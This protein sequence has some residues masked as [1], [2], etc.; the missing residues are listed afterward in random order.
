[1]DR[2]SWK[3]KIYK[4]DET[5]DY[6]ATEADQ[7]EVNDYLDILRESGVTNMFGA[8]SYIEEE[9]GVDG[10]E[11]RKL[12]QNWME[13]FGK[14]NEGD[15]DF[16]NDPDFEG[17]INGVSVEPSQYTQSGMDHTD[18]SRGDIDTESKASERVVAEITKYQ[19]NCGEIFDTIRDISDHEYFMSD[20]MGDRSHNTVNTINTTEIIQE[21]KASETNYF[22]SLDASAEDILNRW[23]ENQNEN[24]TGEELPDH[25]WDE[26]EKT[27]GGSRL[28][29]DDIQNYIDDYFNTDYDGESKATED[30]HKKS[31][32]KL[33]SIA[34]MGFS[35]IG[36]DQKS[37]D[38]EP[39]EIRA[40]MEKV[41]KDNLGENWK[42]VAN[43]FYKEELNKGKKNGGESSYENWIDELDPIEIIMDNFDPDNKDGSV[44]CDH[45]GYELIHDGSIMSTNIQREAKDHMINNHINE[46]E[47][48]A[49]S[50]TSESKADDIRNAIAQDHEQ[51][52]KKQEP[53]QARRF[54]NNY[55]IPLSN[56][57]SDY[58]PYDWGNQNNFSEDGFA[59]SDTL[60][61]N[62]GQ[63]WQEG[64]EADPCWKGYK[65]IGMK[66]KNGK[67][68]PNCVPNANESYLVEWGYDLDYDFAEIDNLED[69]KQKAID[70]GGN[71][72][73]DNTLVYSVIPSKKIDPANDKSSFITA[74]HL[75]NVESKAN[76]YDCES[77][78]GEYSKC[79][80]CGHAMHDYEWED[81]N[82]VCDSCEKGKYDES[83]S[84]EGH[85]HRWVK[86][87][88]TDFCLDCDEMRPTEYE[89]GAK[90]YDHGESKANEDFADDVIE[91]NT[92]CWKCNT[93]IPLGKK[94]CEMHCG[95]P[96]DEFDSFTGKCTGCGKS[97]NVNMMMAMAESKAKEGLI[98]NIEKELLKFGINLDK[99]PNQIKEVKAK[100][101]E[102][103]VNDWWDRVTTD[104]GDLDMQFRGTHFNELPLHQQNHY[105]NLYMEELGNDKYG[106]HMALYDTRPDSYSSSDLWKDDPSLGNKD[107]YYTGWKINEPTVDSFDRLEISGLN[108]STRDNDMMGFLVKT[109]ESKASE[110]LDHAIQEILRYA[111]LNE[112]IAS[113]HPTKLGALEDAVMLGLVEKDGGIMKITNGGRQAQNDQVVSDSFFG[114]TNRSDIIGST[115]SKASEGFNQGLYG[116]VDAKCKTCGIEFDS[117]PDMDDH[118]AMNSDHISNLNDLDSDIPNSD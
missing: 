52:R 41:V 17:K 38:S 108:G 66:D 68:V 31:W 23:L 13:N 80:H 116:Y 9:F 78:G 77:C 106:N 99:D 117:I 114:G 87:D 42:E 21:S 115:E 22:H 63:S 45:C 7:S 100:A 28:D 76:E 118:Y 90:G 74:N 101:N 8:G 27:D 94:Y 53:E 37:W 91:S 112:P 1:M 107:Q 15:P 83:Y 65:Q 40:E 2:T 75:M 4:T 103:G 71:V 10:Q 43:K 88:E 14:S 6:K 86:E 44:K 62:Q 85:R 81:S 16:D 39:E 25:L 110:V 3:P 18:Y 89:M 20:S 54:L 97:L 34:K 102:E 5:V 82:D 111:E 109:T 73:L 69:A 26:I 36:Y 60:A 24:V 61:K 58:Y 49:S 29:S 84:R 104:G 64:G 47:S 67:Q 70:K 12:L 33:D 11:A 72:Y 56:K 95:H 96:A 50:T 93:D 51:W 19:C 48:N 55:Q 46:L 32:D 35:D 57:Q 105:F 98:D 92:E 113:L 59:L 79:P 30:D